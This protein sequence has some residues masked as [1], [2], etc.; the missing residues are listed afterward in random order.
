MVGQETQHVV[1]LGPLKGWSFVKEVFHGDV[2]L[3]E[4]PLNTEEERGERKGKEKRQ[5]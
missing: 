4:N 5:R 2:V 1:Q 3:A